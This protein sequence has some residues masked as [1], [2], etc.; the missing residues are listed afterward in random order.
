D[1]QERQRDPAE[2]REHAGRGDADLAQHGTAAPLGG[3]DRVGDQQPEDG[4]E[5]R[6][7]HREDDRLAEAGQVDA[8]DRGVDVLGRPGAGVR[9]LE[10]ADRHR[11]HGDDEAEHHVG[12]ERQDAGVAGGR[13]QD[14]ADPRG[15]AALAPGR[16]GASPGARKGPRGRDRTR[17]NRYWRF[18]HWSARDAWPLLGDDGLRRVLL[19]VARERDAPGRRRRQRGVG[20]LVL[21][22]RGDQGR[23]LDRPG[24][25]LEEQVLALSGEQVL[26]PQPGGGRVRRG[27]ADRLVVVGRVV[28]VGRDDDLQVLVLGADLGGQQVIPPDEDR[29]LAA[30]H[31]RGAAGDRDEVAGLLELLEEG[32]AGGDVGERAAVRQGRGVHAGE[33]GAGL[34]R[35]AVQRHHVL[36][37]AGEQRLERG[38][39]V[40]HPRA[41]V[42]DGHVAAVVGVVLAARLLGGVRDVTPGGDLVRGPVAGRLALDGERGAHVDDVRRPALALGLRDGVQL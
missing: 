33:R 14:G 22:A 21:R 18:R 30:L 32:D 17:G 15:G 11:D 7:Q 5:D 36:V 34:S 19:G 8:V 1:E 6:R 29:G 27:L 26:L 37:R 12:G 20:L 23:Q 10:S 38:R 9:V 41:V 40:L 2:V 39:R 13:P 35:V 24:A 28:R 3:G 4:R 25:A 16:N 42:A 31:R